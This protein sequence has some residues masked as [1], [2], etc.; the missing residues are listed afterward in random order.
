LGTAASMNDG[1]TS[2]EMMGTLARE[3]EVRVL[4]CSPSGC[5]LAVNAPIE[6]GTVGSLTLVF[7]GQELQDHVRVVRCGAIAGAGSVYHVGAQFLW[8]GSL[9]R[10][11]LRRALGWPVARMSATGS[12][13]AGT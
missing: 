2:D 12:M 6:V 4:N 13:A 8:L 1:M 11:T 3:F 5:L 10:Q 7:D 9:S